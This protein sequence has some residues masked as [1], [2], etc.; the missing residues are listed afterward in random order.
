MLKNTINVNPFNMKK[1]ELLVFFTGRCKHGHK[2][3]EH[4]AC[5]VEEQNKELKVGYLDIETTGFDADYHH[6]LTYAIKT[7]S[8]KEYY[9]GCIT[10]EDLDKFEFDKRVVAKLISDM[11]H[12]DIV[13]TYYGTGFDIPF[14]RARALYWKLPFTKFGYTKHKDVYYM[15][16]RLL[17]IHRRSL[18][19]ATRFL[20]IAGKDHV[21][22]DIWQRARLGDPNALAYVSS[23]NRKDVEILEKLH[24]RLEDYDRGLVKSV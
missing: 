8:K 18:E 16:K 14:I 10:K 23:H 13:I 9:E 22:G 24:K 7:R 19:A 4:P 1:A 3:C 17:K 6:M 12:Y 21:E 15:V 11:L 5:F 20:G 2:Y